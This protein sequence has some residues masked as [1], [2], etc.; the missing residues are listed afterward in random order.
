MN[1][2]RPKTVNMLLAFPVDI[3]EWL[4]AQAAR[5]LSPM[6]SVVLA[7]VRRQMDAERQED[8]RVGRKVD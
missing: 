8:A 3:R 7:A 1:P 4:E 5:T 2:K 6:T